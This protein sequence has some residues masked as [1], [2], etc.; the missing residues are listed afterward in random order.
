MCS[1]NSWHIS[2]AIRPTAKLHG[3]RVEHSWVALASDVFVMKSAVPRDLYERTRSLVAAELRDVPLSQKGDRW[4]R[5]GPWTPLVEVG[6][7]DRATFLRTDGGIFSKTF[8]RHAWPHTTPS[9]RV[10]LCVLRRALVVEDDEEMTWAVSAKG[11]WLKIVAGRL[12]EREPLE[13]VVAD[14]VRAA[15]HFLDWC[16][17]LGA[18]TE[19]EVLRVLRER[20]DRG[21]VTLAAVVGGSTDSALTRA[22]DEAE[23]AEN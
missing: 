8:A 9:P 4:F 20:R 23:G 10:E 21:E 14:I 7:R 12:P 6:P 15:R 13:Q 22:I 5:S 3:R 2:P 11:E 1:L 16:A 18:E 17:Q 19:L